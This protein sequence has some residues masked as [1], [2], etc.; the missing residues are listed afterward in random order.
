MSVALGF[1]LE[2]EANVEKKFSTA[3]ED[4]ARWLYVFALQMPYSC[5]RVATLARIASNV[6][7]GI[8]LMYFPGGGESVKAQSCH[9]EFLHGHQFFHLLCK[10]RRLELC[11]RNNTK[12]ENRYS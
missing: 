12:L 9:K 7:I 6:T 8:L 10:V 11:L 2:E 3:S 4:T 5:K 1:M